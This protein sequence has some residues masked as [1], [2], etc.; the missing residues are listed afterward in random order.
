[1]KS[2]EAIYL[3][4]IIREKSGLCLEYSAFC[5]FGLLSQNFPLTGFSCLLK[6]K[7]DRKMAIVFK[8]HFK[9]SEQFP[10]KLFPP[11]LE[12]LLT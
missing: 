2:E 10:G 12:F 7:T 11:K 8:S 5:C 1:M 3:A 6:F 4:V 9:K